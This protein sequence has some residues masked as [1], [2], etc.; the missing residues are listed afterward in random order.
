MDVFLNAVIGLSLFIIALLLLLRPVRWF[1]R[2]EI[3]KSNQP[4]D[5]RIEYTSESVLKHYLGDGMEYINSYDE[6]AQTDNIVIYH[7][8]PSPDNSEMNFLVETGFLKNPSLKNIAQMFKLLGYAEWMLNPS[9]IVQ[10]GRN[11]SIFMMSII[12]WLLIVFLTLTALISVFV[13]GNMDF[14]VEFNGF[15]ILLGSLFYAVYLI[16]EFTAY[17]IQNHFSLNLAKS[18]DVPGEDYKVISRYLWLSFFLFV[19]SQLGKWVI[20][21]VLMFSILLIY[22]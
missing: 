8:S 6:E 21:I 7:T 11:F 5:R 2:S 10:T 15:Y 4:G 17:I 14:F 20:L 9:R 1:H 18:F 16:K 12:K 19:L 22:N 3:K 13:E